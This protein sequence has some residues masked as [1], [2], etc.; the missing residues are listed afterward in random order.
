MVGLASSGHGFL[1]TGSC[2]RRHEQE[3]QFPKKWDGARGPISSI[4]AQ[5]PNENRW[6]KTVKKLVCAWPDLLFPAFRTLET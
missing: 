1:T 5:T 6:K 4:P 3:D 2:Y